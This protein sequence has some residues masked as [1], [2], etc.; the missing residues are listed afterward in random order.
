MFILDMVFGAPNYCM[1]GVLCTLAR[2]L[3][4][5]VLELPVKTNTLWCLWTSGN[6]LELRN[7]YLIS[8]ID[9]FLEGPFYYLILKIRVYI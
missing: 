9:D 7:K 1:V 8:I 3:P 6:R 4:P 2:M 5:Y